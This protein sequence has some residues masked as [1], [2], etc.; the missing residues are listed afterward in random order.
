[1]D[2]ISVSFERGASFLRAL[3]FNYATPHTNG[4]TIRPRQSRLLH[5]G[6]I[7]QAGLH[8]ADFRRTDEVAY[9]IVPSFKNIT[10][11]Y[12]T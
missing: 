5:S 6:T 1:M 11:I 3:S 2:S 4:R 12:H 8:E 9:S 7:A 10:E